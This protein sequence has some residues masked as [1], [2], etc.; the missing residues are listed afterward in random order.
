M[1]DGRLACKAFDVVFQQRQTQH[2]ALLAWLGGQMAAARPCSSAER[3]MLESAA[4]WRAEDR[5][6]H[7]SGR[8][9]R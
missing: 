6:G 7:G 8:K 4:A 5:D 1:G 3:Q 9:G 2:G